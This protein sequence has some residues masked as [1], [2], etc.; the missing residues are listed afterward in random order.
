MAPKPKVHLKGQ[1]EYF[2]SPYE[3]KIFADWFDPKLIMTKA[4]RKVTEN[5]KDVLPGITLFLGTVYLG[6]KAYDNNIKGH[7]F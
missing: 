6:D 3:Q 4:K 1:I 2:T 5:A 7:R